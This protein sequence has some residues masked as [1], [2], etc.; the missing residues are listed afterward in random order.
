[1]MPTELVH[2]MCSQVKILMSNSLY[3]TAR[4]PLK[5]APFNGLFK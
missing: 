3:T 1:M 5:I 4:I 2:E